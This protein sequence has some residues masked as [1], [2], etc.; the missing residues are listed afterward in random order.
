MATASPLN[1]CF[2]SLDYPSQ[3]SGGGVGNQIH[4][5][6]RNLVRVGHRVTA[7]GLADRRLPAFSVDAGIKVY[8]VP[9]KNLHWY[10]HKVPIGGDWFA[11][12]IRE[13]EYSWAI[14]SRVR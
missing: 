7:M 3:F 8:R 13:L 5:M 4:I 9:I 14:Y 6:G 10:V 2:A 1:I 11:L 12:A